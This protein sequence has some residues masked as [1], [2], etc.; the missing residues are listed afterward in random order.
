MKYQNYF[1]KTETWERER[2]IERKHKLDTK[3]VF[4]RI[5]NQR[6]RNSVDWVVLEKYYC[7]PE[8][9]NMNISHHFLPICITIFV[10]SKNKSTNFKGDFVLKNQYV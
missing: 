9:F 7:I 1:G 5:Q 10:N 4:D 2:E 6:K 3:L 8:S